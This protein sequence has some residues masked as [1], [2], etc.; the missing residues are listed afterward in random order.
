[1]SEKKVAILQS[2]FI[3]WKG[4]FDL[5]NI[6]DEFVLYDDVQYTKG[7]W[8]NR[9]LIKTSDG[10]KWLTI[11][12]SHESRTQKIKE[13][14]IL[15][16]SWKKKIWLSIVNNYAKTEYFKVFKPLF[17]ELFLRNE[18]VFLS[19]INSMF[20]KA[21]NTILGIETTISSSSDF[22]LS[23]GKS[24]RLL[25]I[26]KQAGGT[27]YI[28][29]PAAKDY[30]EAD[31]FKK[32]NIKVSWMDYSGYPEYRQLFPPFD[33]KV[34]ILDLIFNEGTNAVKYMKSF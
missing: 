23:E 16:S 34:T 2:N 6:V 18:H 28:S 24:E 22:D 7:D 15:D 26:V 19:D 8:R 31:L 27:E 32:E 4:Y 12:V 9:N 10:L 13:T 3:P 21:I 33:H 14:K 25:S 17:E 11:P 1:M 5:I 20:I 29:G 30:L